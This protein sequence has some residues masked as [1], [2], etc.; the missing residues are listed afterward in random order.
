MR[1]TAERPDSLPPA[2][3]ALPMALFVVVAPVPVESIRAIRAFSTIA[4][5][6]GTVGAVGVVDLAS[7]MLEPFRMALWL[8]TSVVVA[9]FVA[10]LSRR[11]A[12][13]PSDRQAATRPFIER[14]GWVVVGQAAASVLAVGLLFFV[15][16]VPPLVMEAGE[17]FAGAE[18][19]T[20]GRLTPGQYAEVISTRL[21]VG[22]IGGGTAALLVF[23]FGALTIA[24]AGRTRRTR[25]TD[26]LIWPM[27]VVVCVLLCAGLVSVA[28][29]LSRYAAQ[30]SA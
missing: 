9:G 6:G 22:V 13:A 1:A 15:A 5:E 2:L 16:G 12:I 14:G 4:R 20:G 7:G 21:I 19:A 28:R 30:A 29:M 27:V 25:L 8:A 10:S 26:L 3:L 11:G 17:A 18:S 23:L 24:T